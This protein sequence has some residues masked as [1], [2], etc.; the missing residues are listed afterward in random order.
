MYAQKRQSTCCFTG[1]RP[2]KLPWN[3]DETD[4]RCIDLKKRIRAAAE[5]V[6]ARGIRHFICGMAIGC[7]LYFCE[8]I[9][10]MR[11]KYKDITIEAA[12]PC[13]EQAT[14]WGERE[15]NRYFRLVA[16][17]DYE[18][19]VQTRYS[20]DCMIKRNK[21]MVDSASVLIAVYS[22]SFGGTMQTVS[23]AQKRGLEIIE[24]VP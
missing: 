14:R 4:P 8:E 9:L 21:Y 5:E 15:R 11:A 16:E 22:G 12:I 2:S 24:L 23:Y 19:M 7:D 1:H 18:T 20:P 17:C 6:Y 3:D 10:D 13:E